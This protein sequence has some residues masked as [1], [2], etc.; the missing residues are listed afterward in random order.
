MRGPYDLPVQQHLP[1]VAHI[2]QET[3]EALTFFKP[4]ANYWVA[5]H[6]EPQVIP[7]ACAAQAPKVL[8]DNLIET[9]ALAGGCSSSP[10][11]RR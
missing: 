4:L 3:N 8:S 10:S 11:D 2:G 6:K 1:A 7:R 5:Q 9:P